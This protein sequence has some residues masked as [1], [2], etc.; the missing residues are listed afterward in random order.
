MSVVTGTAGTRVVSHCP[1]PE[2][3]RGAEIRWTT[4]RN[5]AVVPTRWRPWRPAESRPDAGLE[6][7]GRRNARLSLRRTSQMAKKSTAPAPRNKTK[8]V[9]RRQT[10]LRNT[11]KTPA[12]TPAA[13]P[14]AAT[15]LDSLIGLLRGRRGATV[16][17]M[18]EATGWQAHSVRGALAGAL[19]KRGYTITSEKTDGERRYRIGASA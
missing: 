9:A 15:K 5:G 8:T 13:A 18:M 14:K 16:P 4:A 19:K 6:V 2:V 11:R 7:V 17:D 3:R 1:E 12:T 10:P